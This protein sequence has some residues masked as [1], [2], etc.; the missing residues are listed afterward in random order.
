LF[1]KKLNLKKEIITMKHTKRS[2]FITTI[3]MVVLLVVALSTATF[4]WYTSSGNASAKTTTLSSA[5]SSSANIAI[6]WGQTA[7]TTSVEFVNS[8]AL[9]PMVPYYGGA[10]P[11]ITTYNAD[12]TVL[13]DPAGTLVATQIFCTGTLQNNNGTLTFKESSSGAA[14][15]QEKEFKD[16]DDGVDT[17]YVINYNTSTVAN[18]TITPTFNDM[19]AEDLKF[20]E[21][22]K[23]LIRIA[24]FADSNYIGTLGASSQS[25]TYAKLDAGTSGWFEK[26]TSDATGTFTV[27][28]T[29]NFKIPIAPDANGKA[30][31]LDL[32]AWLDGSLLVDSLA[33]FSATFDLAFAA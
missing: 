1:I 16:E 28:D 8:G 26:G 9:V 6:G 22:Y 30:V 3:M 20:Y 12:G 15:W 14:A 7:K 24:V 21:A 27:S 31:K 11:V 19:D 33:G 5:T 18:V 2:L 29:V 32:F 17:L 10:T 25:C 13:A 4:A 23:S